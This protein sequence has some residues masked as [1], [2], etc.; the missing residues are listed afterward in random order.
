MSEE[1]LYFALKYVTNTVLKREDKLTSHSGR[2]SGYLWNR[3]R[4]ANAHQLMTAACHDVY[5]V[6]ATYAK[7]C[8]AITEVLCVFHDKNNQLGTFRSCYC[9]GDETAVDSAAPGK[10]YQKPL[11]DIV[12]GF[13][14]F[15]VG[16]CPSD[17][18]SRHPKYLMEK[19][20]SWNKP[21]N[22]IER[23]KGHLRDISSDKSGAIM[24]CVINAE[25][26]AYEKAKIEFGR[27]VEDRVQSR[28]QEIV[29]SFKSRMVSGQISDSDFDLLLKDEFDLSPSIPVT[30][31]PIHPKKP[32]GQRG[33][34][35]LQ[36]RDG[37]RKWSP[38]KKLAYIVDN[39]DNNTKKYQNSDRQWL[40]RATKT[41]KCFTTCC[42]K[43]V[44]VFLEK[45]G[46][47]ND[48]SLTAVTGCEG[49]TDSTH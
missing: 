17:P 20:L 36:P 8:D 1:D 43:K 41:Y 33:D 25:R 37:F 10:K 23:L 14:E 21:E 28:L 7:D 4:G 32:D 34:K 9:A 47:V 48:F 6:A 24:G 22:N 15:R 45:Y 49:C 30:P 12:V 11:P 35:T 40:L 39:F 44:K 13:M 18:N 46:K 5:E 27:Q 26:E 19:I 38:E 31:S 42:E 16:V 3:I 2:K 29:G